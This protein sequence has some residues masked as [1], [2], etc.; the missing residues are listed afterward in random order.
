MAMADMSHVTGA[1]K[2]F[3]TLAG[4]P[5]DIPEKKMLTGEEREQVAR[6]KRFLALPARLQEGVLR[7]GER[8]KGAYR[9]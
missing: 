3:K 5:P 2:V 8:L 9:S 6:V 1:S 4:A 7:Y